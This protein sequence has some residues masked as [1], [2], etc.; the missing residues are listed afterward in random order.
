MLWSPPRGVGPDHSY[1]RKATN[2]PGSLNSLVLAQTS[3][4]ELPGNRDTF[5]V[6]TDRHMRAAVQQKLSRCPSAFSKTRYHYFFSAQFHDYLSFNVLMA[7]SAIT[8]PIIQK[9]TII[10]DSAQPLSS[11]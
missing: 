5:I 4:H 11:K 2:R 1:P 9:R 6:V 8:M 3:A 7:S 10:F